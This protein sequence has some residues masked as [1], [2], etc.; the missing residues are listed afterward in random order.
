MKLV[1][2]WLWETSKNSTSYSRG[3]V[4]GSI[5]ALTDS[6][7]RLTTEEIQ[8]NIIHK[9]VGGITESDVLLA[10]A[11]DA[12]IIGFQVRPTGTCRKLAEKEEVEIRLYSII[13]DAIN[14]VKES[15]DWHAFTRHEGGDCLQLGNP[16]GIQDF[17]IWHHC[18]LHGH[19][20]RDFAKHHC[21]HHP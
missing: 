9:G 7:Q 1:V 2:D 3:D 18:W 21:S 16:R 14:E 4:D 13:Y 10:A 15:H 17:Q 11:S 12:I 5:E 8:V 19:R 6:L 20:W